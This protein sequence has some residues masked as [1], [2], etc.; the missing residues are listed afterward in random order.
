MRVPARILF[1]AV[2]TLLAFS[3]FHMPAYA[4]TANNYQTSN[5][6]PDVPQNH[7]AY[8]QI[9]LIDMLSAVMCQ[10]TGI[11][12]A[13]P[14]QPCLG[15]N[16]STG[17]IGLAP[18]QSQVFGQAQNSSPQVG[19]AVGVMTQYISAL[20]VPAVSSGQYAGYLA[21]NFGI[22]KPTYA[23][24]N[25]NC[26][27]SQF[28]YGFCGLSPILTLWTDIRDLAYALLTILFIAIGIGVMLRFRVDPRTVMT[29]QN[30]IPR[31]IIAIV[32]ITFSFAIAGAMIDLMWTVTYAGVNFISNSAPNSKI[33]VNCPKPPTPIKQNAETRLVDDPISFTNTI[34]RAD[35]KGNFDNGFVSLADKVA[36]SLGDL[37]QQVVHDLL[38]PNGRSCHFSW[39]DTI[40]PI[41]LIGDT[42]KCV[43]QSGAIS[44]FLWITEFLVKLIIII[45]ILIA[46]FRL[47]FQLIKCYLTFLIFVIMGP[48][49]I[50]LGLIPGR[51][52]GFEKWLR[53]VFA[54]L[55][56]FPLVAFILVFAR[57][58]VDAVPS[59]TGTP[60]TFFVPP[61][62]G[63]PNLTTFAD[64][65]GFGAILIAPTI[66]DL[67][68]E[69][70]KATGQA[71][72][73]ASIA[74][75]IGLGA[76]AATAPGRKVWDNLNRRNSQTGAPEGPLAVRRQ[77]ITEKL[78][79]IGRQATIRKSAAHKYYANP[80]E[81]MAA[82]TKKAKDTYAQNHPKGGATPPTGGGNAPRTSRWRRPFSRGGRQS[83][84]QATPPPAQPSQGGSGS[85][86]ATPP[87]P[88]P[89]MH[90]GG[91]AAGGGNAGGTPGSKGKG[92]NGGS[93]KP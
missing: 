34:F 30:Q 38:F 10:L 49:W 23:A 4:Q 92:N 87:S 73:G 20:Y 67:I 86:N 18:T 89:S 84:G 14:E 60:S 37:V 82:A 41:G 76:A 21:A 13:D 55:A 79:I 81:G 29:L 7:H 9:V 83:A 26:N 17:K 32:L 1:V 69:R 46:L 5:T 22:V 88:G 57:V 72:Y 78:P 63:N 62:V 40:N 80:E 35:C 25:Q 75:G 15:V 77:L 59:G 3:S 28:G 6:D 71:K 42:A 24:G 43:L 19:G 90:P 8:T 54:N 70:M 65:M 2:F 85:S 64:L 39:W 61:L 36:S 47:W 33:A 74:A 56:V 12:P 52:M 11:D 93:G 31:V 68:K 16:I 45:T 53:I 58:I 44:I 27:T 66:P 50:V 48:I 51:P 91:G